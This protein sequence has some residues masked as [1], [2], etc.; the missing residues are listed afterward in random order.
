MVRH[1]VKGKYKK[2]PRK[3]ITSDDGNIIFRARVALRWFLRP[4]L[5]PHIPGPD[6]PRLSHTSDWIEDV[7]GLGPG[8]H[9]EIT[10]GKVKRKVHQDPV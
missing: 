9:R 10:S 8:S 3:T 6:F 1:K 2:E 4:K 5:D 7:A